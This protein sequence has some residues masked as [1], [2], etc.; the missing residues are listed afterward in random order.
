MTNKITQN[1]HVKE[2]L[3]IIGVL[4]GL[5][6]DMNVNEIQAHLDN[7]VGLDQWCRAWRLSAKDCIE[8][9]KDEMEGIDAL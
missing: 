6:A 2:K 1:P 8:Q 7:S 3:R 4:E 9:L 5:I